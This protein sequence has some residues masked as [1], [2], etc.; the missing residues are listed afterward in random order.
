MGVLKPLDSLKALL[1][2]L[3]LWK[4]IDDNIDYTCVPKLMDPKNAPLLWYAL[5]GPRNVRLVMQVVRKILWNFARWTSKT[6]NNTKDLSK[7]L[8]QA[9]HWGNGRRPQK[10]GVYV[11][12]LFPDWLSFFISDSPP[13]APNNMKR[14]RPVIT[15]ERLYKVCFKTVLPTQHYHVHLPSSWYHTDYIS[16]KKNKFY[17]ILKELFA[18]LFK[19]WFFLWICDRGGIQQLY[20]TNES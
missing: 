17:Y 18:I 7:L 6:L 13:Y 10:C 15:V 16:L 11:P 12:F 9:L 1:E 14:G 5:I 2:C 19:N 20:E 3:L 4:S 8:L